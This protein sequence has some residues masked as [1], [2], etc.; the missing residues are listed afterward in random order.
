MYARPDW[1]DPRSFAMVILTAL[2]TA[3]RCFDRLAQ[4]RRLMAL[5]DRALSDLGIGR[6]EAWG[7]AQKPAWRD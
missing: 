1:Q 7:E 3:A 5:D 6:G 2:E 4:R